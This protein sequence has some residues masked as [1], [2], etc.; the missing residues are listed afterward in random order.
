R[1]TFHLHPWSAVLLFLII[2]GFFRTANATIDY[3]VIYKEQAFQQINNTPPDAPLIWFYNAGVK[4]D[5]AVTGGTVVYPNSG[6]PVSLTGSE[7]VYSTDG[8]D[9]LSQAA[10]DAV[11]PN[12]EVTLSIVEN[13][14]TTDYGPF[15]ITGDNYP[16]SPYFLNLEELGQQDGS[17]DFLIQWNSF[18]GAEANDKIVFQIYE[19][20]LEE[21][22]MFEVMPA[23]ITGIMIP[24]GSLQEFFSYDMTLFFLRS[25]D[26]LE[27]PETLI[28]YL[29]SVYT[30]VS[31]S[32]SSNFVDIPDEAVRQAVELELDIPSGEPISFAEMAELFSLTVTSAGPLNL[33][34]LDYASNLTE[35]TLNTEAVP[36]FFPIVNLPALETVKLLAPQK[37]GLFFTH[38][39]DGNQE[40]PR[41]IE[42]TGF[43]DF[44]LQA[45]YST[46]PLS[47]FAG[48][49][50][51][52]VNGVVSQTVSLPNPLDVQVGDP[53]E[54]RFKY[55]I[56]E[57]AKLG[58]SDSSFV[59]LEYLE[60]G[61]LPAIAL[62]IELK[63]GN[64]KWVLSSTN[65]GIDQATI[66]S[67]SFGGLDTFEIVMTD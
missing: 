20:E 51:L 23:N 27:T 1:P 55:L 54:L 7:G 14:N 62:E 12:G 47:P 64:F 48:G 58:A 26:A 31:V 9:Y 60:N 24:G 28:G 11:F 41:F 6:G 35:L 5:N 46:V 34:G 57:A 43:E 2:G 44:G 39:S 37:D 8:D 29:S 59:A 53:Y 36:S 16:V 13:G 67:S 45:Q 33:S 52:I 21:E 40:N 42:I 4:G 30:N 10:M 18:T 22:V 63:I 15:S 3:L 19:P 17:Q 56:L 25:T 32:S 50:S 65:T 49:Y 38:W 61:L 66:L